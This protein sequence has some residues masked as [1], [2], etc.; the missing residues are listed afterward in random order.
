VLDFGG[1]LIGQ[2]G[3]ILIAWL[4]NPIWNNGPATVSSI[5]IQ[6]SAD[7]S[8]V[9]NATTCKSTLGVGQLCSIAVQFNPLAGGSRAGELVIQD[10]ALNSPQVVLLSGEGDFSSY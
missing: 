8:I 2:H 5:A 6:G 1:C 7:F 3:S 9:P 4:A 10:N